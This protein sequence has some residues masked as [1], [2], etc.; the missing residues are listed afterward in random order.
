MHKLMQQNGLAGD[1]IPWK[2][3]KEIHF[4]VNILFWGVR[5]AQFLL[6]DLKGWSA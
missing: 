5:A 3:N 1:C 4:G 6:K 2:D